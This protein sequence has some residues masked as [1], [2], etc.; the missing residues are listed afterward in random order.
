[1]RESS[2]QGNAATRCLGSCVLVCK[3]RSKGGW[4]YRSRF[5]YVVTAY[6]HYC[7]NIT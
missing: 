1:M 2:C 5:T 3:E 4:L 6:R 7:D